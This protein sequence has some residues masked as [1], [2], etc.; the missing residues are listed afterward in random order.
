M[1][2]KVNANELCHIPGFVELLRSHS[3]ANF[4]QNVVAIIYIYN[5]KQ[6]RPGPFFSKWKNR[7]FTFG[8][9][10]FQYGY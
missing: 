10:S 1:G 5:R 6:V 2:D 3:G 4:E 8:S 7:G 9:W